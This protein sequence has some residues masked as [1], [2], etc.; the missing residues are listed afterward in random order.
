[1]VLSGGFPIGKH[2]QEVNQI[3]LPDVTAEVLRVMAVV[4]VMMNHGGTK[5]FLGFM[6]TVTPVSV[7]LEL[8]NGRNVV[9]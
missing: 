6:I 9:W 2:F 3:H 1:M 7:L 8:V 4:L 5:R